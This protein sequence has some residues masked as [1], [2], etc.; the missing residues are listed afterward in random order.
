MILK[1]RDY[2]LKNER[3]PAGRSAS[4][5]RFKGFLSCGAF[6]E[7]SINNLNIDTQW[8]KKSNQKS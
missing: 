7:I 2:K 1:K 8:V 5:G 4:W 6:T 3:I